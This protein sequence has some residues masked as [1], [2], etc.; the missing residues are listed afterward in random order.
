MQQML[1]HNVRGL[2]SVPAAKLKTKLNVLII[3]LKTGME[4]IPNASGAHTAIMAAQPVDYAQQEKSLWVDYALQTLIN[5]KS[6]I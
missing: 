3:I 2:V 6:N 5:L 1:N 4:V